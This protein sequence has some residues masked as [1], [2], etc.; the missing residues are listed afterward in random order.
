MNLPPVAILAGGLATRLYPT[1]KTI[2]KSLVEVAG[3]PFILHQLESL[4]QQGITR[5]VLC[6]GNLGDQIVAL[7]GNGQA[8]DLDIQYSFDGPTLLGTGGAIQQA[9]PLLDETFF[10]LYG[11]SYLTCDYSSLHEF[12]RRSHHL[13]LLT[14]YR[15]DDR[16]D[17]SNII[18][19]DGVIISYDKHKRTPDMHYIDYGL[20]LLSREVF[21]SSPVGQR[22]DLADIYHQLVTQE[23]MVGFEVFTRFYEIGSHAG[24]AETRT[25]FEHQKSVEVSSD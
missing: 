16:W 22:F 21:A 14:V 18:F 9:L 15:N 23:Q 10:V 6:V 1:T 20:S 11:D 12:L 19:K 24:L 5:I 25:Y 13:G 4:R 3:K 2:P 8:Y 17:K 7:L